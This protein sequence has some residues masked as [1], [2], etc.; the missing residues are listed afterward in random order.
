M[1]TCS[2][3]TKYSDNE[4]TTELNL[5]R[6]QGNMIFTGGYGLLK[7]IKRSLGLPM[8]KLQGVALRELSFMRC[9]M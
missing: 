9:A 1:L 3:R 5:I 2:R 8:Y 4:D 6:F 7:D